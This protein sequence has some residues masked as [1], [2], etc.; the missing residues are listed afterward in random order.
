MTILLTILALTY[1]VCYNATFKVKCVS[2]Q[3][4]EVE[5]TVWCW[6]T[7]LYEFT[8]GMLQSVVGAVMVT[9]SS[10]AKLEVDWEAHK[11]KLSQQL[12]DVADNINDNKGED[13][14]E[15]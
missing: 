14:G 9:L 2:E 7:G 5:R 6:L 13:D 3:L 8:I 12:K 4:P 10:Y 11:A 1:L 15:V